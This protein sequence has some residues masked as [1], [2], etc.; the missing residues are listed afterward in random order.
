MIF[1]FFKHFHAGL[2][3]FLNI[4]LILFPKFLKYEFLNIL[5]LLIV[6]I[7]LSPGAFLIF[8]DDI[9][10]SMFYELL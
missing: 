1:F 9:Y 6:S 2:N 8:F 5:L 7:F 4:T 3:S 10:L